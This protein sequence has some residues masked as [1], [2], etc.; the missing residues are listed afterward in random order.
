MNKFLKFLITLFFII[1][2]LIF[3][4][5]LW[6]KTDAAKTKITI[7][8]EEVIKEELGVGA[9][10]AD[11][12]ISL[13]L[14]ISAKT[15]TFFEGDKKESILI[16]DFTVNILPSMFS[17]WEITIW[18]V[19][20][21]ELRVMQIPN[22]QTSKSDNDEQ[23]IFAPSVA[24]KGINIE[25]IIL[26]KALT[27]QADEII[28]NLSS[29]FKF[30]NPEKK[31]YFTLENHL[32]RPQIDRN[33]LEILGTYDIEK[34]KLELN[35]LEFQSNLAKIKGNFLLDESTDKLAG[36]LQY[37]SD[38]VGG[39]ITKDASSNLIGNVKL[40]GT[41]KAPHIETEG[42]FEVNIVEN[43]HFK[44]LPISWSSD[45]VVIDGDNVRGE[46]QI[47]QQD[48]LNF[49]GELGYK[50]SKIYLQ[51]LKGS[52]QDF[53]SSIDLNF[54]TKNSLLF[55]VGKIKAETLRAFKNFLPVLKE[56]D[57]AFNLNLHFSSSDN[58]NQH[59]KVEGKF[60]GLDTPFAACDLVKLDL[61]S[62]DLWNAKISPSTINLY[63]LNIDDFIVR[64]IGFN[65]N[66]E[67]NGFK[68]D[69][70]IAAQYHYP[71]N[72]N[73]TS[74]LRSKPES[75]DVVI[76]NLSGNFGDNVLQSTK[77]IKLDLN[78]KAIFE[79][80]NLRIGEGEINAKSVISDSF[81]NAH[82]DLNNIDLQIIPMSL[83]YNL[84]DARLQGNLDV[85][86][87]PLKPHL[88]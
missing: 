52:G 82:L 22:F 48:G 27:N 85:N 63:T 87:S 45:F 8:L 84:R 83:P 41:Y 15:I 65:I 21:E 32:T 14:I 9:K 88:I 64:S 23:G 7:F 33:S 50:D 74:L 69:S 12:S 66:S 37:A 34:N 11:L 75:F 31:L 20:A 70:K 58:K 56:S 16:K 43:D 40:L 17:F 10:I 25:K 72:L 86:G 57:G 78:K 29:Y 5:S 28:F 30:D 80:E 47:T 38:V 13:P 49:S 2:I 62:D 67:K 77:D 42:K 39:F 1:G 51:N 61:M 59:L 79:L 81:V 68:V 76:K 24:I 71:I 73:F 3:S 6:V 54:N 44:F 4:F 19:S 35:Y 55:G 36:N 46:I 18:S 26:D 60:A 53:E